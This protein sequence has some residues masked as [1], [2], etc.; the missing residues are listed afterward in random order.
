MARPRA[1]ATSVEGGDNVSETDVTETE[2][3]D[4]VADTIESAGDIDIGNEGVQVPVVQS[5]TDSAPREGDQTSM[6][7]KLETEPAT[8][9]STQRPDEPIAQTMKGGA[10]EHTPPDP[11]K[12]DKEGRPRPE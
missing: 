6:P 10:G 5:T 4:T 2:S 11:E 9:V 8:P 12:F 3:T 7:N 1:T